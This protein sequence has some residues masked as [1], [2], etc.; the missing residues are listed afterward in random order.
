MAATQPSPDA[1]APK[2]LTVPSEGDGQDKF[3]LQNKEWLK[4]QRYILSALKVPTTWESLSIRIG[5]LDLNDEEM[6]NRVKGLLDRYVIVHE[7][8]SK[9]HT[10]TFPASVDLANDVVH[11]ARASKTYFGALNKPLE[12]LMDN[13][14][15]ERAKKTLKGIVGKL[16]KDAKKYAD[17]ADDVS[18]EIDDFHNKSTEDEVRLKE[19]DNLY[20]SQYGKGS[21]NETDLLAKIAETRKLISD[22]ND[23]YDKDVVIAAT[24]PTYAWVPVAGII[25]AG[26]VAGI[27]GAEAV[28][29]LK[30]IK[31]LD[32]EL[33]KLE[34]D[35]K[36]NSKMMLLSREA[37]ENVSTILP[38]LQEA[39]PVIAKIRGIWAAMGSDLQN[40]VRII[41]ED[42]GQ[43]IVWIKDLGIESA[44]EQWEAVGVMADKYRQ[45]AFVVLQDDEAATKSQIDE[46]IKNS[47]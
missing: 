47:K 10:K 27:F 1:L 13:E 40:I 12:M 2:G 17:K 34:A 32:E 8:V 14:D 30:Q 31:T 20:Q 46:T 35:A 5:S 43:A 42:I 44:I 4:L 22:L 26:V 28:A 41:D 23:K 3:L 18:K 11:Y 9:W 6:K 39:L 36:R 38:L 7:N 29:I 21:K 16:L 25:A 24:T 37:H 19:L 15:D 33:D 45:S